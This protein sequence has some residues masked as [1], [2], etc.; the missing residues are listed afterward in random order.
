MPL[1]GPMISIHPVLVFPSRSLSS[2]MLQDDEDSR[3]DHIQGPTDSG[4][5]GLPLGPSQL[6][7]LHVHLH[8]H[9][10]L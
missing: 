2:H 3:N 1:L 8:L 10:W 6:L 7:L 5:K 9:P 4:D